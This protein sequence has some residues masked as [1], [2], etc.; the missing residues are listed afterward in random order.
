MQ[1]DIIVVG[2][3][4][5]GIEAALAGA[6]LGKKTLLITMLVEQ[7]GAA[8]CNPAIGGLAKGHL[9]RELDALGG[10]MGL[11]T[12]A[13][14]IQFRILNDSKGAAVQGT[15]AQIDMDEYKEYM[16]KV[17]HNTANL[18]IYQDEVSYLIVENDE[19]LG[20]KTKLGEEFKSKKTILTTGTFMRGLIHIGENTYEAGR[21][22]ELPSTTL[23][24]QLKE[25][26]LNVGR[27]KTGTPSRLDANSIDFSVMETHGGDIKPTPFSFRTPRKTFNPTQYPCYVTYTNLDT[28]EIISQNFHRAPIYTG[29]IQGS[30]PR[31]CPSIEDKVKR[32]SERERHQLFLEPQTAKCTE[33]YINGMSSSLP[34]EIQKKMI[35][36]VKGLENARVIR[37]GYAIEY[38]YVDP[39]EL[40]HT[41]E[42]K[43]IKNLYHA[44][45]INAT[46]GYEEAAAQGLM[47]SI[48][49]SLAIDNKEPFILRRDEAYIG[50]LIDDLVTKGTHEPYRM[51]TSRAEYRLLLREENADLRLSHYGYELGLISK[52]QIDKVEEKRKTLQQAVEFMAN[53]WITAKKET[54]ELLESIG[55]DKIN[56]RVLLIDLIGRNTI[57]KEKF[58]VLVPSLKELDDYFKEQI[59]IEAKYYRYI[60]KQ[61]KQIEK[62]KKMLKLN[63]PENFSYRGLPGLSNEVVEKLEKH[64][65]PTL[66]NASLISGITPAALDI[67]HLNL[68]MFVT[69]TKK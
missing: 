13:T 48:N 45:Q 61:Q 44:G 11:C 64:T 52:E 36:S 46:T 20:V 32:F 60:Q 30:G 50:V 17:C 19:V 34:I 67:I 39:T 16:R 49:A 56:D 23:S 58:D 5:A 35:A 42:T 24:I 21:A 2:A 66:Y 25:L 4:H 7:I 8:S 38:D 54:L 6:R 15:R 22:W 28:H 47:A 53:T 51:F 41:L 37:Y 59:I 31:Y 57:D 43:K 27:L 65:P 26:G 55:E 3:G 18:D 62:M 14:G 10:E 33:Y 69:N 9:V 1:Y 68:N 29:Q 63:I 12:D 40:K